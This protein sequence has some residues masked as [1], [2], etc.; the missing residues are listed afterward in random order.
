MTQLLNSLWQGAALTAI[1]WALLKTFPRLSAATRYGIWWITLLAVLLLPIRPFV[2]FQKFLTQQA[3]QNASPVVVSQ[4]GDQLRLNPRAADNTAD[5]ALLLAHPSAPP[6]PPRVTFAPISRFHTLELPTHPIIRVVAAAWLILSVALL[7]RLGYSYQAL[8]RLKEISSEPPKSLSTRLRRLAAAADMRRSPCLLVCDE[9]ASPLALGFFD[10]VILIPPTVASESSPEEFDHM[11]L[12][13]LGHLTR[14]DDWANLLQQLLIAL[15][16]IQ[17][18]LFWISRHL[19]LEREAACDDR[20]IAITAAPKPYAT[21]L[22]RLAELSLWSRCGSLATGVA[23]SRSQLYRRIERLLD[24]RTSKST[25]IAPLPL[26]AALA[27]VACLFL[28]TFSAPQLIALTDATPASAQTPPPSDAPSNSIPKVPDMPP[29]TL[30]RTPGTQVRTIPAQP[31]EKLSIDLDLCNVKVGS[32]DQNQV[33]IKITQNGRDIERF[34]QHHQISIGRKDHEV[35]LHASGDGTAYDSG[36]GDIEYEILIPTKF[37]LQLKNAAGNTEL[38]NLNG[39]ISAEIQA[40]N[41]DATGCAGSFDASGQAGN[42][43]L[44]GMAATASARTTDGNIEAAECQSPLTLN[45]TNGNVDFAKITADV[46]AETTNGNVIGKSASG[47]VD[48]ATRMGNVDIQSFT[49]PSVKAHT[50]MGNVSADIDAEPKAD[51][52]ITTNMGNAAVGLIK[53]A[54]VNLTISAPMGNIDTDVRAGA[55]NG[56]GPELQVSSQMG[57]VAIHKKYQPNK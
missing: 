45:T 52:S 5:S 34:L 9:I 38:S 29:E 16:P 22:T 49:G 19:N 8:R 10:P 11:A 1:V 53:S 54:A 30:P 36:S 17:P 18:A 14:Y 20:V 51:C 48:A 6:A 23:S 25:A 13:E 4:R 26:V 43:T 32:W 50:A 55:V 7:A 2:P 56:G 47:A 57:N 12:H 42:I 44:H 33:Q 46:K 28:L 39:A 3:R 37:D 24:H 21:S 35:S 41:I 27:V 40:G 31:G 15:F